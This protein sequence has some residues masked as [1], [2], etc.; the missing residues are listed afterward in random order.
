[1]TA[2][3]T[4][5]RAF[6]H[7]GAIGGHHQL[8]TDKL[9]DAPLWPSLDPAALQG[10]AGRIV[11]LVANST[12][13]D[14]AAI[15]ADLLA[16]FGVWVGEG[17]HLYVA[18]SKH[19]PLV[20]PLVIGGTT[21][22][23]KGTSRT[24]VRAI[25]D[26]VTDDTFKPASGLSSGEGLIE[27]VRDEH[28][29]PL[30]KD[31]R[32]GVSDKRVLV[33]EPEFAATLARMARQGNTLGP[34]L[35]SAWD[36]EPLGMLNRSQAAMKA[37]THHIGIVAHITPG[38]PGSPERG[39]G[40]KVAVVV[41]RGTGRWLRCSCCLGVGEGE[42]AVDLQGLAAGVAAVGLDEGVVDALGLEPGEQEVPESVGRHGVGEPGGGGVAGEQGTHAAGGVGLLPVTTR[43]GTAPPAWRSVVDVQGEGFARRW[44]GTARRGPCRLCR[45]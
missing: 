38:A 44:P 41:R 37:R 20:W 23:A 11:R 36:Q 6:A 45:G 19:P 7:N 16:T 29:T 28:G 34:V 35:R 5:S 43:T 21:E 10:N 30:D 24:V 25:F 26:A 18:N 12:E 15:L 33:F 3:A 40:R 8:D 27:L 9:I 13:A 1:M 2:A 17:P 39:P 4:T 32:E 42:A 31:F 22:G 14:P